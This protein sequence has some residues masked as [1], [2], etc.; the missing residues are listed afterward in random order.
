M[1]LCAG[2]FPASNG[3][4][5]SKWV[6]T[7]LKFNHTSMPV[8]HILFQSLTEVLK[9]KQNKNNIHISMHTELSLK[10]ISLHSSV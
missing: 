1:Y 4:Y 9:F 3:K 10:N 7:S 8:L 5:V 6:N 2:S